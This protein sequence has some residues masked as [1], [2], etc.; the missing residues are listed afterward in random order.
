MITLN[1]KPQPRTSRRFHR[2]NNASFVPGTGC[3]MINRF[4]LSVLLHS[5]QNGVQQTTRRGLLVNRRHT[6]A[7]LVPG[8]HRRSMLLLGPSSHRLDLRR[9]RTGAD[10]RCAGSRHLIAGSIRRCLPRRSRFWYHLQGLNWANALCASGL[11]LCLLRFQRFMQPGWCVALVGTPLHG[12]GRKL[13]ADNGPTRPLGDRLPLHG[14]GRKLR[15]DS[16]LT[17]RFGG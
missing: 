16:G 2:P 8:L 3:A 1:P 13:R 6:H 15:A 7:K 9:R 10:R 14:F 5:L 4:S 17:R 12:F 11:D